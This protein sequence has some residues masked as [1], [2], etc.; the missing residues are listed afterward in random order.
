MKDSWKKGF[1]FGLTSAII[2]TLGMLVGLHSSTHSKMAVIGGVIAIAVADAFSDALGMHISEESENK[3]S[4][5]EVWESTIA[6]F[7]TKF[8]FAMTFIV[9]ILLIESLELAII[10]SVVYG[11][12]LIVVFSLYIGRTSGQKIHHV[13]LEHLAIAVAVV[14]ITHYVGDWIGATFPMA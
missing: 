8:M 3:H 12:A 7:I 6:T 4:Q 14:I 5:Q 10:A 13:V 9:P 11:L 2:T 1:S